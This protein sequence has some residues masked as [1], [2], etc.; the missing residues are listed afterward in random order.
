MMEGFGESSLL[1]A[2]YAFVPDPALVGPVRHRLC[3]EIQRRF[4]EEGI[5][6]PL[7][8]RQLHVSGLLHELARPRR[9]RSRS[10]AMPRRPCRRSRTSAAR[11]TSGTRSWPDAEGPGRSRADEARSEPA[12]RKGFFR[13]FDDP[14]A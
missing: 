1:F 7:P 5:V 6:I 2:L 3:S 12:S 14:R 11:R 4:A 8:T 9:S 13:T 10:A